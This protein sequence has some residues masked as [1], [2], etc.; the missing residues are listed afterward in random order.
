MRIL[1]LYAGIGGNRKRWD[2]SHDVVAV[3]LNEEIAEVYQDFFPSDKVVVGDAHEYLKEHF[4][5][6]DFIWSSPPCPSHSKARKLLGVD[7]D[8]NI[9]A[10]YPDMKLWQEIL[11]L[12]HH[13][14]GSWVV[15][16]VV[17]YYDKSV[18]WPLV[19]PT[20]IQRHYFWSNFSLPR[21]EVD[22]DDIYQ[23]MDGLARHHGFDLSGYSFESV[24]KRKVLRN[25]VHPRIGEAILQARSSK[26]QSLMEVRDS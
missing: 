6:F 4:S 8:K 9:E 15:E 21:V 14:D 1:N 24:E 23:S 11:L 10:I 13:F 5:E 17:P 20:K 16:N 2:D 26:Q 18:K 12:K 22:S 25:C 3:E 19:K 7:Q